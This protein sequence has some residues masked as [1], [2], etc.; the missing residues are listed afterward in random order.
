M[1][2]I[3]GSTGFI[4]RKLVEKLEM[5]SLP[6]RLLLS[7]GSRSG[8]LP[9]GKSYDV[10]MS[11]LDDQGSLR[12][13]FNQVDVVFHLAGVEAEGLKADLT[14]FEI[15]NLERFTEIATQAGVSRFYYISHL[16]ADRNSAYG[17]LKAKGR[18]EEIVKKSGLPYTI[19]RPGWLFGEN[20]HFTDSI[21]RL[22]KRFLSF[23]FLPG[24]GQVLMQPLWV[25]DFV[26][27]MI[28]SMDMPDTVNQTIELGGPEHL[29]Y[30]EIAQTVGEAIGR[31]PKFLNIS[32]VQ[33][34]YF[35]QIVENNMKNPPI[36]VYWMDYLAE[37]RTTALDSMARI[38][39]I[40]PARMKL[41][42]EYLKGKPK[43]K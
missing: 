9:T 32:A 22:L 12:A 38:F 18:G 7:P 33:Y 34:S 14:Q 16:G 20:D 43:N 10:V 17:L 30:R 28:W 35:T 3:S 5:H 24:E 40:N 15:R 31:R 6:Y 1:I 27:A 25:D 39:E 23:Y 29:S 37:N 13:A 42:L 2:L 11:S 26:T 4:G 21:A 19:F 8:E 41:K 36:N